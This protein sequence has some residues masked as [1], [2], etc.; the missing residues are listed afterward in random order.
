MIYTVNCPADYKIEKT[1]GMIEATTVVAMSERSAWSKLIE[2]ESANHKDAINNLKAL[3]PQEANA[4]VGT[5]IS[6][7]GFVDGK[8]NLLLALT[9]IG[10]PVTAVPLNGT[11]VPQQQ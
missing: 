7:C 11:P 5:R 6:S 10:T 9:Y 8:G 1:F 4:I 2:G 3:M